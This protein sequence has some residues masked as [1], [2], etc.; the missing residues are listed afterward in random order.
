MLQCPVW[1][2]LVNIRI[3]LLHSWHV[4]SDSYKRT[5]LY[6]PGIRAHAKAALNQGAT[7][8]EV[9]EVIELSS[10]LSIHACN[11]GVPLLA[12]V[13][14]EE[15][16]PA[17][18]E[19]FISREYDE[20]QKALQKEFTDKRGYWHP[21]WDDF[22]RMDPDFFKAYLD[23]SSVPWTKDV[24]GKGEGKGA[25]EPKVRDSPRRAVE[26]YPPRADCDED[27]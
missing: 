12:E 20:R 6:A 24:D 14:K 1:V 18:Y 16:D 9:L 10:T 19:A 8:H 15:K 21:T 4:S 25:L 3:F 27:R 5:H 13:L 26:S 11:V 7:I 17:K 23:F 22:L 2:P